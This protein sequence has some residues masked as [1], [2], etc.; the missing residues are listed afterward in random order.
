[1]GKGIFQTKRG[2]PGAGPFP[3]LEFFQNKKHA[4]VFNQLNDIM[5]PVS[6]PF[7]DGVPS[8]DGG[9]SMNNGFVRAA[10]ATPKIRVADPEYN[11]SRVIEKIEECFQEGVKVL[12]FPELCLT[13]Y[14]CGDLFLHRSL[15]E[16]A[17]EALRR[18]EEATAGK[19]MLVF[20]GLPWEVDGKLYN[21]AAALKDGRLL[22]LIPKKNL[23]NYSEFYEV[24]HFT[25][26]NERP[27][28]IR[29]EGR[30]IPMGMNLLFE[31][32]NLPGLTVAAEICEDV[33]VPCPPSIRHCTAGATLIVNCS[34]S[35]ETTGKDAYRQAL[36]CGQVLIS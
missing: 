28:Y 31:C 18:V 11:G 6:M 1:M 8:T 19:D 20:A 33:W 23:P 14:T 15:L 17:K 32:E 9:Q 34:A 24:R 29:W 2:G 4:F 21:V 7:T 13:A 22:G 25:P 36:I 16:G 10:A 5:F 12:V 35:D 26:G 3:A 27:V 30:R